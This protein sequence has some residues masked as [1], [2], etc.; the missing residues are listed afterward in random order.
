M[1][2]EVRDLLLCPR[3]RGELIEQPQGLACPSCRLLYPVV[4]GVAWMI[5]ERAKKWA[6]P[7]GSG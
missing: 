4:R 2:P 7:E 1:D 6:S 3:C 5:R